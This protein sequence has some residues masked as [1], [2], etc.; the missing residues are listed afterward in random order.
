MSRA[1]S[2]WELRSIFPLGLESE[3]QLAY[4]RTLLS[5]VMEAATQ[6]E[7][8]VS[9]LVQIEHE[10][11]TAKEEDSVQVASAAPTESCTDPATEGSQN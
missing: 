6:M 4:A 7:E 9:N 5:V 3:E 1:A 10:Q 2:L 11:A 8:V